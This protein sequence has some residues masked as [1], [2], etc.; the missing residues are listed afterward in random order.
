MANEQMK[1][2]LAALQHLFVPADKKI[3]T[4]E[5]PEKLKEMFGIKDV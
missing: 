3:N 5:V 1:A 4:N 2:Q